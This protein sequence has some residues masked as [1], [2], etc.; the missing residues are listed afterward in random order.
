MR[1]L[2][3]VAKMPR[4][5]ALMTLLALSMALCG[6]IDPTPG[7]ISVRAMLNGR[8]QGCVVQLFNSKGKQIQ[9]VFTDQKGLVYIK[10]LPPGNYSLKFLDNEGNPYPAMKDIAVS[11]GD[12]VIVDV[13][14]SETPPPAEA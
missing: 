1:K 2:N 3:E 10:D 8:Q 4:M 7:E 6:C 12:S 11:E 5:I 13:E 9:E 14:L